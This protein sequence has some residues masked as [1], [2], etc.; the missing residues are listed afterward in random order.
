M[1]TS[2]DD[3]Q[4]LE[5]VTRTLTVDGVALTITPVLMNELPRLVRT[6]EPLLGTLMY[7]GATMD[8]P[9]LMSLLGAHGDVIAEAVALCVRQP[10]DWVGARLPDRVA[11]MAMACIEVNSD[12]FSRALAAARSQAQR[13]APTLAAR[14]MANPWPGQTPSTSS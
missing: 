14:I 12:F 7:E 13:V 5:P 11:V 10:L 1:T 8:V 6:V 4:F 2:E 3:I 9:R